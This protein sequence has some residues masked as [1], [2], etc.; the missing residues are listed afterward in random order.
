MQLHHTTSTCLNCGIEFTP[1]KGSHGKYCSRQCSNTKSHIGR[2]PRPL[3]RTVEE[4]FWIKVDKSGDCWLWTSATDSGGYPIFS[5]PGHRS[6]RVHRYMW[7]MHNGAIPEN[8][9]ICHTCDVRNCIRI[10]HL[11]VGS[12]DENMQDMV[13]KDR[14]VKGDRQWQRAH[15]EMVKHGEQRS[16][17][18]LTDQDVRDI[19]NRVANGERKKALAAEY[20]V[21]SGAISHIIYKRSWTH[22]E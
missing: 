6:I 22:V 15:P 20:N 19:R 5:L 1:K 2:K 9:F 17:A 13:N 21:S 12:H 11:F 7:E 3:A 14:Q 4:R 16:N 10:D 18:K 8:M